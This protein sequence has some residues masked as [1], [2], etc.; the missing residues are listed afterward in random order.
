MITKPKGTRDIYGIEAKK[1]KYVDEVIDA[2][3]EKY[4]YGLIRT[5][6]FESSEVF[7]RGVGETTDIVS[8]ETYDFNDRGDRN[9]TLRP[10]GTAGVVRSYV[11]NKMFGDAIQP[12]KFYYNETM[13]RYERP[14]SGRMRELTQ[15]GVEFLGSSDPYADAEVISIAVNL[16]KILGLDGIKVNVNTLGDP[17][18]RAMYRESLMDYLKPHI[19]SLCS[20][21]QRRYESNPL[22]IIDCKFD[23][24]ENAE[25]LNNAPRTIDHLND[26]SKKHFEQVKIYL[27]AMDIEYVIDTN[28]VR[29]LDYYTHTVFEVEAKI[30]GFGAHNILCGGGRYDNLVEVLDGPSTPGVGFA[31]GLDRLMLALE[32]EDI[33]LPVKD[34]VDISVLYV[35]NEEKEYAVS[36]TQDLRLNGF[37]TEIDTMQRNLKSQFKQ[38]DRFGSKFL[39]IINSDDIKNGV[40]QVKDV[41]TKEEEKISWNDLVQFFDMNI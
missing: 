25:I 39:I 6:V 26:D 41:T 35:T 19:A 5:P 28:I 13:Y 8:K 20:D 10:E 15:F 7:H 37:I 34:N 18:S 21:C 24:L 23:Q 33:K 1:W 2:L 12:K 22:R 38:A 29:G 17:K 16:Y 11:E 32:A 40:V 31:M 9:M 4:N 30:D 3:C 14:Q 27:D 36:L